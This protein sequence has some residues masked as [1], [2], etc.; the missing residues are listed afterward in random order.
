MTKQTDGPQLVTVQKTTVHCYTEEG[1]CR[2]LERRWRDATKSEANL[3]CTHPERTVDE[4]LDHRK[5]PP[6]CPLYP[7]NVPAKRRNVRQEAP[8]E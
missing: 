1:D 6:H 2:W 7:K 3:T 8:H 4:F 5:T